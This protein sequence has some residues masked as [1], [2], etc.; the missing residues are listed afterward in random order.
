MYDIIRSRPRFSDSSCSSKNSSRFSTIHGGRS[1]L[2]AEDVIVFRR[3]RDA[4]GQLLEHR[5]RLHV[6]RR[7][8]QTPIGRHGYHDRRGRG[9]L[10][11]VR[12]NRRAGPL[13]R[14]LFR[15]HWLGQV[16]WR[17]RHGRGMRWLGTDSAP[18]APARIRRWVAGTV[19]CGTACWADWR[20]SRPRRRGRRCRRG[21]RLRL[22]LRAA[23]SSMPAGGTSGK[24]RGLGANDFQLR[25]NCWRNSAALSPGMTF[26]T[27]VVPPLPGILGIS[28]SLT[29]MLTTSSNSTSFARTSK[30]V[31][32][33]VCLDAELVLRLLRPVPAAV[34]V[35]VHVV[36]VVRPG[37]L[38]VG[39]RAHQILNRARH[40]VGRQ[41]PQAGSLPRAGHCCRVSRSSSE[42]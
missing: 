41:S 7:N 18:S 12:R 10:C 23:R 31:I 11:G 15:R 33:D 8:D 40:F 16:D 22:L 4:R 21:S 36:H 5:Q 29:R 34:T 37:R 24:I 25:S 28:P 9:R 26:N 14:C 32:G 19:P 20:S 39:G 42:S 35:A 13:G 2:Q 17:P 30:P 27:R 1:A 6:V 38:P 3:R